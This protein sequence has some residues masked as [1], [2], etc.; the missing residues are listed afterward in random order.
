MDSQGGDSQL[1]VRATALL[2][3]VHHSTFVMLS[4][5]GAKPRKTDYV[6]KVINT[7]E[8]AIGGQ[9]EGLGPGVAPRFLPFSSPPPC[10][11]AC[12]R[13]LPLRGRGLLRSPGMV[14]HPHWPVSQGSGGGARPWPRAGTRP[15][16]SWYAPPGPCFGT[17][18]GDLS[19]SPAC[20]FSAPWVAARLQH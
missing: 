7:L 10:L 6:Q 2:N 16:T 12:L 3:L 14:A 20:C 19:S 15:G 13:L 18:P 4:A 17:G 1:K 5:T 11:R 9:L 8:K